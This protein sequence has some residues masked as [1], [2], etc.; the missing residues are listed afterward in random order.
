[1]QNKSMNGFLQFVYDSYKSMKAR[2][3]TLVYEGEINHQ[4]T[5]AFT[6]LAETNMAKDE[7]ANSV[8]KKVFHVMVE[9]LQNVSKHAEGLP[10]YDF[11]PNSRGIFMVSKNETYYTITTGNLIGNEKIEGLTKLLEQINELDKDGLS[12]LYKTQIKQGRLSEKGGAGLG[13]I[14]IA[15][16]TGNKIDFNFLP[17]EDDSHHFFIL[18]ANITRN[19]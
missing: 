10:I 1:M 4:I 6:S 3:I 2:E 12:I 11:E 15:K 13:F 14:D 9:C 18:T 7:E 8:Q 19:I 5:K 17:I 16:K